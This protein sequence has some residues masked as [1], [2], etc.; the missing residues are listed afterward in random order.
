MTAPTFFPL[1]A[2]TASRLRTLRGTW[3]HMQV[4]PWLPA[5]TGRLTTLSSVSEVWG[6]VGETL[7][8]LPWSKAR[9][10]ESALRTD[11]TAVKLAQ[12]PL[13]EG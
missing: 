12:L 6:G 3:W 4:M 11:L 7:H 2:L 1:L 9:M 5:L 13:A 10:A 8:R